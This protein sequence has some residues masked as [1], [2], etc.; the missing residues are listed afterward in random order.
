MEKRDYILNDAQIRQ[1]VKRIAYEILENNLNEKLV[2]FGGIGE[3]GGLL[4]KLIAE[5]VNKL[6]EIKTELFSISI[7]KGV[8]LGID[9]HKLR[10]QTIIIVDDVLNTGKTLMDILVVIAANDPRRIETCF[11]AQ[12]S[13]RKFPVK[14]DYVGISMATTFQEHICFDASNPQNLSVYL[15]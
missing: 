14:G 11:L 10:N 2:Y 5:E 3:R 6:N 8:I 4:A 15:E 13:H 9:M 1:K 7:N 12:R